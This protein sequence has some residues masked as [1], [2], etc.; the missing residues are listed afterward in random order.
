MMLKQACRKLF[1]HPLRSWRKHKSDI[2]L[3]D[4]IRK[5]LIVYQLAVEKDIFETWIP[6][7]WQA[8]AAAKKHKKQEQEQKDY[9]MLPVR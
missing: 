1:G 6:M 4:S 5:A 8:I 3:G 9:M 2:L 7:F